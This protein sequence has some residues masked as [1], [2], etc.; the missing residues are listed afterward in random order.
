MIARFVPYKR[1]DVLLRAAAILSRQVPDLHIA[2]VG[3][4][5]M[6]DA[7]FELS[8]SLIADLGIS[9]RVTFLPF[10]T[11]IRT[12]EAAADV[13][14]LCSDREPLGTGILESMAM[15][16]PVVITNTGGLGE[17]VKD[18]D[19]GFV[20]KSGD[21]ASLADRLAVLLASFETRRKMGAKA[22]AVVLQKADLRTNAQ[23]FEDVLHA[24]ARRDAC[25]DV[26][27]GKKPGS[28]AGSVALG[29]QPVRR[30]LST[31]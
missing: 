13:Q 15:G 30:S 23:K 5:L 26:D 31:S 11:D 12:V 20:I 18:G 2:L 21:Y 14:V 22:R 4:V 29:G 24:A 9:D 7:S 3:E 10:Q 17:L 28:V 27:V 25:L 8:R 19:S 16:V 6:S 1:H